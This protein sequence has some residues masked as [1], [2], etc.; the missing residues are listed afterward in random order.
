M[1]KEH[2]LSVQKSC[3]CIGISRAAYYRPTPPD[4]V[5]DGEVIEALNRIVERHGRWG[6]WKCFK[7]LRSKGYSWNHK[8]VYRVYRSLGLNHKRR[9]KRRIPKREKQPLLVPQ[10]PNQVWS[11]D[12]MSDALYT[13]GRF[14]TFNVIDDFNRESV[15]IEVDTSI[16]ARRLIRVFEVLRLTRGQPDVLRVDNGPEFTSAEF[17]CW[18]EENGMHVQYIQPGQPNQNAYIERFNRTY[19]EEVLDL[20]IF[21][22]L[23]EVREKTYWWRIAY[24]EERPHDALGSMTPVEYIQNYAR[25]STYELST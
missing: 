12:F 22:S 5:K 15:A 17:T 7:S 23:E 19:R 13:R 9:A 10:K 8:R 4:R 24:N 1:T 2:S 3:S 25:N 14:R 11:A 18:A 20:Y 16:T 6:F 21:E